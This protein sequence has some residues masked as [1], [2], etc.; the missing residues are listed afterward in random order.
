MYGIF[1]TKAV[2]DSRERQL[3]IHLEPQDISIEVLLEKYA[4]GDEKSLAELRQRVARGLAA[5]EKDAAH[6]Q[7]RFSGRCS[8]ASYPAGASTALP[9]PTFKP[10]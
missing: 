8:R 7:E 2:A 1:A 3:S 4:K 10:H 5:Q 9:A 6:W